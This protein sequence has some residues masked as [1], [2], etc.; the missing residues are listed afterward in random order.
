MIAIRVVVTFLSLGLLCSCGATQM[1]EGPPRPPSKLVAL[2]FPCN[3][4]FSLLLV[5]QLLD[6]KSVSFHNVNYIE[7]GQHQVVYGSRCHSVGPEMSSFTAAAGDTVTYSGNDVV[8]SDGGGSCASAIHGY[9][10]TNA[11]GTIIS[12]QTKS[13]PIPNQ[14]RCY[15]TGADL[16]GISCRW[17][18]GTYSQ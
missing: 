11:E 5:P 6:G 18:G 16:G 2:V 12:D 9:V 3:Q 15:R 10:I 17:S 8:V 13:F 7:P 1:Y 14:V 4:C